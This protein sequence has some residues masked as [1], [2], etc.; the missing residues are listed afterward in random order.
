MQ[1]H[2]FF[3]KIDNKC[4]KTYTLISKSTNVVLSRKNKY[5]F[6]QEKIVGIILNIMIK[7]VSR[8]PQ[9]SLRKSHIKCVVLFI[10][11]NEYQTTF[12]SQVNL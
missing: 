9:K 12:P 10:K 2:F 3:R 7:E 8:I 5:L 1:I 11:I 6:V 4:T